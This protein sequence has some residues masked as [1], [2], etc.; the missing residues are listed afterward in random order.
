M[1]ENIKLDRQAVRL[2]FWLLCTPTKYLFCLS[3]PVA[4]MP[5]PQIRFSTTGAIQICR[6]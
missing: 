2:H 1:S 3:R 6:V 4:H 5:A